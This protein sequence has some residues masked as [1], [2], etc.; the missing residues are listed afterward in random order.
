M[1]LRF[2]S[3]TFTSLLL[4]ALLSSTACQPIPSSHA[5]G[6]HGQGEHG[7]DAHGHGHDHDDHDGRPTAQHTAFA[8]GNDGSEVELYVE[9][10]RLV[11]GQPSVFAA[12]YT[13]CGERWTAVKAATVVVELIGGGQRETFSVGAPAVPGIFRPAATPKTAGNR[14][15]VM[16]LVRDGREHI[17]DLGDV[18]V[19]ANEQAAREAPH[20]DQELGS[21]AFTKEQ[22][23]PLDFALHKVVE[24][25]RRRTVRV[26]GE[27]EPKSGG[28]ARVRA[29]AA[30]R[31][32]APA[33]GLVH[34]GDPVRRGQLLATLVPAVG[35]GGTLSSILSQQD[36]A[37]AARVLAQRN[38]DR[39]VSLHAQGAVSERRVDEAKADVARAEADANSARRLL[40]QHR[41]GAGPGAMPLVAPFDGVI[42]S[43]TTS[44]GEHLE[45]G[46]VAFE[47]VA[48]HPLWLLARIP[49]VLHDQAQ[50]VFG[51]HA[52]LPSGRWLHVPTDEGGVSPTTVLDHSDRTFALHL[53]VDNVDGRLPIGA[54]VVVD[55]DVG[56]DG[57]ATYVPE[58]AVV[59]DDG[60]NVVYVQATG[61]TFERRVV[62]V[63]GASAGE[64]IVDGVKAGERVVSIGA[65]T[66]KL[67]QGGGEV[68]H[69]HAH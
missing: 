5:S 16:K 25:P 27:L 18:V 51:A 15:L 45:P 34:V 1:T 63:R 19:Y 54:H 35:S 55:L 3:A 31:L 38:L 20:D 53:D 11:V 12:H 2:A 22:A 33:K 64:R 59:F 36:K 6:D 4:A 42:A 48:Q 46:D 56:E 60:A 62:Q 43:T 49:E 9:F 47:V 17:H 24:R 28:H 67:A 39:A 69:G 58:S 40:A 7:H 30:G 32:V 23:W 65:R 8:E 37:E 66:V 61:E 57:T 14:T 21:V 26:F 29:P 44:A 50:R 41:G 13:D 10:P 52:K 68:G